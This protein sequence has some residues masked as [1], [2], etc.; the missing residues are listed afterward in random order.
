MT[1]PTSPVS[2]STS[3]PPSSSSSARWVFCSR[4][5][6]VGIESL[7]GH[8]PLEP[9]HESKVEEWAEDLAARQGQRWPWPRRRWPANMRLRI[10]GTRSATRTRKTD[11][12]F[13]S[14]MPGGRDW[15]PRPT[16]RRGRVRGSARL[17]RGGGRPSRAPET[18]AVAYESTGGT[19]LRRRGRR[20]RRRR[21]PGPKSP[22][23]ERSESESP[24]GPP[25]HETWPWEG[26]RRRAGR[27]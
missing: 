18:E 4:Q 25:R 3:S 9:E 2:A 15:P 27:V 22:S 12:S 8:Q 1:P 10:P 17:R 20:G 11:S 13:L 23:A 6:A 16:G 19:A 21:G 26:G 24:D 7:V 5:R 14:G